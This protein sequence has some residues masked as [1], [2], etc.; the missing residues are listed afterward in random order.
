EVP[1]AEPQPYDNVPAPRV[2]DTPDTPTIESLV[3]L[4]NA[5][6]KRRRDDRPWQA[7]DT[8]KN[9]IGKVSHPV[10]GSE[11]LAIAVPGDREVDEK[12]L[13]AQ[14]SPPTLEPATDED[15]AAHPELV[16]GYIGPEVLGANKPAGIRYLVD[17]RVGTGTR[18]VT[19]ANQPDRH[20]ID[21]VAGRDFE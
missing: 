7:S 3:A 18:W 11:L 1:P 2:G 4:R 19:G 21:L 14:L 8:L 6:E 9:V 17:P 15:F 13:A 20:V 12:R 10:G 16:R 5:G